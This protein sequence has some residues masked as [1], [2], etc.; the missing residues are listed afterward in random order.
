MNDNTAR[1]FSEIEALGYD[2]CVS[3]FQGD[4]NNCDAIQLASC[5][6]TSADGASPR[7]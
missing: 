2:R 1:T 7:S 4:L 6:S 3:V 5:V